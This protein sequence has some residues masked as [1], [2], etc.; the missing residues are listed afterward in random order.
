[1]RRVLYSV[2]GRLI[3]VQHTSV[4]VRCVQRNASI[5][6]N[7]TRHCV[8]IQSRDVKLRTFYFFSFHACVSQTCH[9][10]DVAPR[11][12]AAYRRHRPNASSTIRNCRWLTIGLRESAWQDSSLD[13][14]SVQYN[15]TKPSDLTIAKTWPRD[16][17]K[18]GTTFSDVADAVAMSIVLHCLHGSTALLANCRANAMS[19]IG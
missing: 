10:H 13:L 19:A 1:M 9:S 3:A 8:V 15:R 11:L 14:T 6:A 5:G 18:Q 7:L 2:H 4:F 16:A 17:A 12:H